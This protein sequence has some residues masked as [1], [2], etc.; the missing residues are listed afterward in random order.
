MSAN[1]NDQNLETVKSLFNY[2]TL[3]EVLE[4]IQRLETQQ[5]LECAET[6]TLQLL[7][8]LENEDDPNAIEA[9]LSQF[10]QT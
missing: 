3:H 9:V 8:A 5:G 7:A 6:M 1:P 10:R 2:A 4:E